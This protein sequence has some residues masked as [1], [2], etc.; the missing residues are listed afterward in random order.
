MLP[1]DLGQVTLNGKLSDIK[2]I[3]IC[4]KEQA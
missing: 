2:E 4:H 1:D 3:I